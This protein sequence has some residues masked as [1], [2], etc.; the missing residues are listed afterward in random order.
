MKNLKKLN[1]QQQK[2]ING[3]GKI[4]KCTADDQCDF[5]QCCSYGVCVYS[6]IP[7]CTLLS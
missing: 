4:V 6:D 1:R 7:I 2:A 3:G 5:F